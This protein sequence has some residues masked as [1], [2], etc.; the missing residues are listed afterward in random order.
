MGLATWR[1]LVTLAR[2][3]LVEW[4]GHHVLGGSRKEN[5]RRALGKEHL[6]RPYEQFYYREKWG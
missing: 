3:M 2:A 6:D 5:E 4:Q 1:I